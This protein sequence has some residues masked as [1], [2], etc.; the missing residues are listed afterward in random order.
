[1]KNQSSTAAFGNE[2]AQILS[3]DD[4]ARDYGIPKTTQYVWNCSNR[5]G[6]RDLTIKVGRNTRYRRS[7]IESWLSARQGLVD[8]AKG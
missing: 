8:I 4:V 3:P 2:S 7:D 1:M 5:Y 6:W